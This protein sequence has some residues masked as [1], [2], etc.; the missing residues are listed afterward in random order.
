LK[1]SKGTLYYDI[2]NERWSMFDKDKFNKIIKNRAIRITE[3]SEKS[4][5][6]LRTL[7]KWRKGEV[8]PTEVLCRKVAL[9]LD[10]DVSE[11]TE[12]K[13]YDL[14]LTSYT[15]SAPLPTEADVKTVKAF[16]DNNENL[17]KNLT[18][19]NQE[20]K[21]IHTKL[22]TLFATV[23]IPF[24]FLDDE[25]KITAANKLYKEYVGIEPEKNIE[26]FSNAIFF[27]KKQSII[28]REENIKIKANKIELHTAP[29]IYDFKH[30]NKKNTGK[31]FQTSKFP[32]LDIDNNFRGIICFMYD[33]TNKI[34][35]N[36]T[37]KE[38]DKQLQLRNQGIK[39]SQSAFWISQYTNNTKQ[40]CLFTND[41]FKEIF[42]FTKEEFSELD[43]D[44]WFSVIHQEDRQRV[45]EMLKDN[46]QENIN[47]DPYRIT[48]KNGN[49]KWIKVLI[50]YF[51]Y[52]GIKYCIGTAID[53][54]KEKK[55]EEEN[56]TF[57]T[58][59]D[60][61][62]HVVWFG[63]LAYNK[64]G[65]RF[66]QIL[67]IN[68]AARIFYGIKKE[69][70]FHRDKPLLIQQILEYDGKKFVSNYT[71]HTY[72][73]EMKYRIRNKKTNEVHWILDKRD[74]INN[75]YSG[76]MYDITEEQINNIKAEQFS[77]I[78]T[79]SF[80]VMWCCD[81]CIRTKMTSHGYTY[82]SDSIKEM[83][84]Y[85]KSTLIKDSKFYSKNIIH[86]DDNKRVA[87]ELLEL[88]DIETQ[89]YVILNYR[90][91]HKNR[92]I[93]EVQENVFIR[94]IDNVHLIC[95][96]TFKKDYLKK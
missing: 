93:I 73:C 40:I 36:N 5:V 13:N 23:K 55:T 14:A 10:V 45:C 62:S 34:L 52:D 42:G 96:M 25:F 47:L 81:Y 2:V 65:K 3:L 38:K 31:I 24:F 84:G 67:Y 4:K 94:E 77:R 89:D 74:K 91:I 29:C 37:L 54:T 88:K 78:L 6:G 90:I 95:G 32:I 56:Q 43:K 53:I 7:H 76:E 72:P 75:I 57:R 22:S 68:D 12:Y 92:Q 21:K 61:K 18:Y 70:L 83:T 9:A 48:D 15:P 59:N 58:I 35:K 49:L 87:K 71:K 39:N 64:T 19:L 79:D 82:L 17:I 20:M 86:P 8:L 51:D 33:I 80:F 30:T 69:N 60:H 26:G 11:F 46:T 85:E 28:F 66:I 27:T 16:Y 63:E 50:N 1:T 41:A 44:I